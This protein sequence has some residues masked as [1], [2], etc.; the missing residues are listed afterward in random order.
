M[1]ITELN[2]KLSSILETA[3]T[4]FINLL[5]SE[6]EICFN[7]NQFSNVYKIELHPTVYEDD[8][9]GFPSYESALYVQNPDCIK[10]TA[11]DALSDSQIRE[12]V[13]SLRE[14]LDIFRTYACFLFE[15]S[16]IFTFVKSVDG[17][18]FTVTSKQR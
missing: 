15:D 18:V 8:E 11:S 1:R 13:G 14:K 12:I 4:E 5:N 3:E 16:T 10:I 2:E 6:M 9:S 17:K 7:K